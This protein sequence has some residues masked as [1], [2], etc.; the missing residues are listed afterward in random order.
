MDTIYAQA[1][2]RGKAGVAVIRLSGPRAWQAIAALCGRLP[3]PRQASVRLLKIE[4]EVLDEALVLCFEAGRSFTGEESGELHLHGAVATV[5]AVLKALGS[6]GFL[7]LAEPG[8]FTRRA[9][10]SGRLDL[11]QVEGLADLIEAETEAQR[12]QALAVLSGSVGRM[13]ETWRSKLIRA[14][15]LMEACIDFADEDVPED[16]TPEVRGLLGDVSGQLAQEMARISV[17]ERIREGF[18]VAIVGR[19]NAGKST[20]LNALAGREAAITSEVA[21]T[22]R[23]VIE[24]R[25]D[26]SG[27]AVTLLDTAGLRDTED[28][29]E[30]IGVARAIAR[31]K[32]ADLRV[33]LL[34]DGDIPLLEP[35]ADDL[36][37]RGKADLG[38]P[39]DLRVSGKT[40]EGID[41]LVSAITTRLS[42]RAAG[43]GVMTRE[44]HRDC[45]IRAE[46][47]LRASSVELAHGLERLDLAAEQCRTA[48]RA[49][50]SLLG[51]VDVESL[52]DEIFSSFCIGK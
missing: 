50:E 25:M 49:L 22:T 36:I 33:F 47:A 27:L 6:L 19:P 23:D 31:A 17:T 1:S 5:A 4:G 18:E 43:A 42:E 20:L 11:S 12:K 44:R 29:I 7:R 46:A 40:G 51:R 37:V 35:I 34:D 10:E 14:A 41:A 48:V 28:Q 8:E 16:V 32:Q 15:A 39:G 3:A 30:A 21:G 38:G 52:L 26:L 45:L 24:V 2:G 13:V 9:M